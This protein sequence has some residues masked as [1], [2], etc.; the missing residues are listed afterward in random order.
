[1]NKRLIRNKAKAMYAELAEHSLEVIL[2][3]APE[4]KHCGHC[5]RVAADRPPQWFSE[6][7][8]RYLYRKGRQKP[9]PSFIKRQ[10]S[11]RALQEIANG[12]VRTIYAQRWYQ[13]VV[14]L[15]SDELERI[16]F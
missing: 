3:P 6:L 16:P 9:R 4:P 2:V 1:M 11:L 14:R 13:E 10:E 7:S 5:I 12:H 15:L 8:G